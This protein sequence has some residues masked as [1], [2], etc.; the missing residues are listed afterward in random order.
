MTPIKWLKYHICKSVSILLSYDTLTFNQ[1]PNKNKKAIENHEYS[2]G[3][4][5]D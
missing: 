1:Y 2:I 5:N 4:S 3:Y